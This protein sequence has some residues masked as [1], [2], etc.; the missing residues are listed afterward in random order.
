MNNK[1]LSRL[2]WWIPLGK[3]DE[4]SA[5]DLGEQLSRSSSTEAVIIDVR[6]QTEWNKSR[7]KGAINVPVVTL[8]SH[9]RDGM[10]DKDAQIVTICLSAH[11]SISAVRFFRRKGFTNVVQLE[12]GMLS[13]WKQKL[14]TEKT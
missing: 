9:Y 8:D 2:F 11:R 7:I 13:W 12:G 5:Q 10:Y 6:T 1:L 3:V 4:I 14:P